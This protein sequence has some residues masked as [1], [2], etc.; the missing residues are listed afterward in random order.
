[1]LLAQIGDAHT[2][3]AQVLDLLREVGLPPAIATRFP[4]QLSGGQQQRVAIARAHSVRPRLLVADEPLSALDVAVQAQMLR[5]LER[6]REQRQFSLLFISHDLAVVRYLCQ[7]IVVMYL[8]KV[9]EQEPTAELFAQPRHPY[10]VALMS[11]APTLG[12]RRR[13]RIVLTG[14]VATAGQMPS[15]CRFHPRC[16][17]AQGI[18]RTVEPPLTAVGG[19][20]V[21]C[22]FPEG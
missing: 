16:W 3:D 20:L 8:G 21:A 9:V 12:P 4:A 17:K 7:R 22:H 10:T 11:A 19:A 2:V 1:L 13:Q 6:I 14:E 15:G 5:L 18:C